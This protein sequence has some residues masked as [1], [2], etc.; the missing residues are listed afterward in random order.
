MESDIHSGAAGRSLHPDDRLPRQPRFVSEVA[1]IPMENG[2]IVDGTD[3]LKIL[4]GATVGSLLANLIPL[5]DGSRTIGRLESVLPEFPPRLVRMGVSLLFQCGLVEEGS[6]EADSITATNPETLAFL[7]R[8]ATAAN[9]NRSGQEAYSKLQASHVLVVDSGGSG[10]E[11]EVLK[12]LLESTGIGKV[13][14]LTAQPLNAWSHIAS[15]SPEKLLVVSLSLAGEDCEWHAQLD[16]WCLGHH[17]TWLRA[18]ID[19][20][21]NYMDLGPLFRGNE[22][23]CFRCFREIHAVSRDV[24]KLFVKDTPSVSNYFWTSLVALEVTYWLARVGVFVT[25]KKFQRYDLKEWHARSLRWARIPGC[26]RCRPLAS[27]PHPR[28]VMDTAVVFEDY[29]GLSS[30]ALS[31]QIGLKQHSHMSIALSRQAKRLPNCQQLALRSEVLKLERNM[32]D[33]L[34]ADRLSSN[35]SLTLDE[36]GTILLMTAGIREANEDRRNVQRWAATA[37]N[38]GSVELFVLSRDVDGLPAGIYFYQSCDHSLAAFE[39]RSGGLPV[40]DFMRRVVPS[41]ASQLPS[42]MV[43]FTG[44]FH[45]VARK[46][47]S[48]GYRLIQFDAGAALSQLHVVSGSLRI[49]SQTISRWADDLFEDQLN[50]QPPLEQAMAVAT[51][52]T[53]PENGAPGT[54]DFNGQLALRPGPPPSMKPVRDFCEMSLQQVQE[55][56]YRE[57]RL[58]EQELRLGNFAVPP[59]LLDRQPARTSADGSETF[60]PF[61]PRIRGGRLVGDILA[62]RTS[63]R[64]FSPEAVSFGELSTM[65][66]C[67]HQGDIRD[68]PNEHNAGQPLN[69]VAL[70]WHVDGIPQGI[71]GYDSLKHGLSFLCS[72]P[73]PRDARDMFVQREFTSVPLVVWISGNLVAACSRHGAYGHRQ[74]LLRA[75]CAG[76]RLWMAALAM[77]LSGCLIAGLVPSAAHRNLGLDGYRR[78][79][80]LAFATG[81]AAVPTFAKT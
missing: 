73:P 30:R 52:C 67:A 29:M 56:L 10:Q 15:T 80:L 41:A 33:I 26:P 7:R 55:M 37:G 24:S 35:Q 76:H 63:I 38:L 59:A 61:P 1:L 75:G 51:L 22:N 9:V 81:R 11:A 53:G 57:S 43:L 13:T 18:V 77:G 34:H 71:Y 65:V 4:K 48:F 12:S 23:P 21:R 58:Q 68:W 74:L 3:Q 78:T 72:M 70:V 69:F 25:A 79:S 50:L 39:R 20:N 64:D 5:M 2:L 32:L 27:P 17:V 19:V 40:E 45:R 49:R 14:T 36:L 44:A 47:G 31:S 60:V 42:A 54:I 6:V 8:Y 16:D 28:G 66:D 46:Y 62:E